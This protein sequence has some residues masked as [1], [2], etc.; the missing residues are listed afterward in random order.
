METE[1]REVSPSIHEVHTEASAAPSPSIRVNPRQS[2]ANPGEGE[3]L[4]RP[5]GV[6]LI[7]C[8]ELGHAPLALASPLAFLEQAGYAPD[9]LDVAVEAF[10]AERVAR[11]RFVGISVPMHT[12]LRLGVRVA[13]RVRAINPACHLCFY[14]LYATLNADYL[15]A[16]GADSVIG[17]EYE[18]PLV[19]LVEALASDRCGDVAGVTK[20]SN[21]P[22]PQ[23]LPQ[24]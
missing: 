21:E 9:A 4:R 22:H 3:L 17:G 20:R 5:G 11:A 23:P 15:C 13:E 7:S 16:H 8:Y 18:E 10:D 14:G 19:A 1:L 12:A 24:G 2:A 6:L